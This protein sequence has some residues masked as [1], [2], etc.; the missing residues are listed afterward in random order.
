MCRCYL[1]QHITPSVVGGAVDFRLSRQIMKFS[2]FYITYFVYSCY[3]IS[4]LT[5]AVA[6]SK[7]YPF[8]TSEGDQIVTPN[9]DGSSGEVQISIPFPFFDQYHNSLFVSIACFKFITRFIFYTALFCQN[10]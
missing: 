6:L 3:Q 5:E 8:G 7:F 10:I 9:D 4:F 1:D 2:V